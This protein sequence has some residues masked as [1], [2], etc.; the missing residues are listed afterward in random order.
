[1]IEMKSVRDKAAEWGLTERY[2]QALCRQGKIEGATK[3]VGAW[4][5]PN[6]MPNPTKS[7]KYSPPDYRFTGTKKLIFDSAIKLFVSAGFE[8][9]SVKDIADDVGIRQSAIYNHFKSKQEIL[10]M[11]YAFYRYHYKDI[12]PNREEL[13]SVLING[14]LLDIIKGV[15]QSTFEEDIAQNMIG[16]TRIVSHR[17]YID[18]QAREISLKCTVDEATDFIEDVFKRAVEIGRIAPI[19]T[20]AAAVFI[21]CFRLYLIHVWVLDNSG[22]RVKTIREK[23]ETIYKYAIGCLTDLKPPK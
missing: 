11:I 19:D 3:Y 7:K 22:E 14:S 10:D 4:F 5:I 6:D 17:K 2:V 21:N 15:S 18:E 1:M 20:H 8:N 12:R 23:Q 13:E 9:V 16:I